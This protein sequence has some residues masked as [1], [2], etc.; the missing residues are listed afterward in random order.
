MPVVNS[1]FVFGTG[2]AYSHTQPVINLIISLVTLTPD[3]AISVIIHKNNESICQKEIDAAPGH[4]AERI[5]LY[6][7]GEETAWNDTSTYMTMVYKSGEA[8]GAIL[9]VRPIKNLLTADSFV[10]AESPRFHPRY[11]LILLCPSQIC[12][13]SS[14]PAY[15]V[16]DYRGLYAREHRRDPLV[17]V[18]RVR[19][20]QSHCGAVEHGSLRWVDDELRDFDPELF[21]GQETSFVSLLYT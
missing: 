19:A 8:Y 6:I 18:P 11:H 5:K 2:S 10:L 1:H 7:V 16:S 14:L 9:A 13:R 12:R 15:Q 4:A 20:E 3:L 21:A 17:S